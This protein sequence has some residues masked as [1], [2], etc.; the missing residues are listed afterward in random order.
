MKTGPRKWW[1][2]IDLEGP[3]FKQKSQDQR[4][5]PKGQ[6]LHL[7]YILYTNELPEVSNEY[8]ILY[9]DDTTLIFSEDDSE[10]HLTKIYT[11]VDI[12]DRYFS[13]NDLLLNVYKTQTIQ[14]SLIQIKTWKFN[15]LEMLSF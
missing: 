5:V 11:E 3:F 10:L 9:A 6:S 4:V 12:L 7:Y 1:Y 14:F 8:T 13:V 2:M 15:L